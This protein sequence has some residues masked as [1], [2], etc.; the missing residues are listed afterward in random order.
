MA[1]QNSPHFKDVMNV[2]TVHVCMHVCVQ[3]D[4]SVAWESSTLW[5]H[6]SAASSLSLT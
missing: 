3:L 5:T 2:V 6:A 1:F 4:S